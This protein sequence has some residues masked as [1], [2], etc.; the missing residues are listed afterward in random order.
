MLC[1]DC[2]TSLATHPTMKWFLDTT[3]PVESRRHS[4]IVLVTAAR[5]RKREPWLKAYNAELSEQPP[6]DPL[7]TTPKTL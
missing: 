2:E 1:D 5:Q 6:G 4:A 3:Q 7:S